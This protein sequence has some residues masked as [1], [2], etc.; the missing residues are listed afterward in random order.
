MKTILYANDLTALGEKLKNMTQTQI[1]GIHVEDCNS[2]EYISQILR[3]PLN[4]VSVLILLLSSKDELIKFNLMNTLFDNLRIILVLP[5]NK[6]GMLS[7]GVK[8]KPSFISDVES[9]M[10]DVVSVLR[11]IIKKENE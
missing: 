9:D 3:Q 1:S 6:K 2:I 5:D 7:L 4:N 8:L 11:Q 10:Q